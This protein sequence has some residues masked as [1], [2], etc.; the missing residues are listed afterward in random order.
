MTSLTTAFWTADTSASVDDRPIGAIL[1]ERATSTPDQ[2]ALRWCLGEEVVTTTYAGLLLQTTDAAQRLVAQA[3]ERG[4]VAVMAAGSPLWVVIEYA[5][6]LAGVA[7]V[8]IDPAATDTEL[9][10]VLSVTAVGLL[11]CDEKYEGS[12]LL[13]R[14]RAVAARSRQLVR[15]P[16]VHDLARWPELDG[17]G[18]DLPT[19]DASDPFLVQPTTAVSRPRGAVVISHRAAYNSGRLQMRHLGGNPDD[20]WFNMASL[21]EV[22][23]SVGGVLAMLS[24]GGAVALARKTDAAAVLRSLELTRA[25]VVGRVPTVPVAL[26]DDPALARTDTSSVRAVVAGAEVVPPSAVQR[27]EE[28]LGADVIRVYDHAG[29]PSAL[30]TSPSDDDVTKAETVGTPLPRHDVRVVR[31]SGTTADC[32]EHGEL[33]IRSLMTMDG[34][35]GAPSDAAA[36]ID[37]EGWL[38]TGDLASMDEHG[39]VRIHGRVR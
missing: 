7:L 6:A 12:P 18:T 11:L 2:P 1:R 31:A 16:I 8:P 9:E 4:R 35:L 39:V 21:H 19:V 36:A 22:A 38:H 34:Y 23:G 26:A 29:A 10:R 30:M 5:A 32:G 20:C 25:T 15:E 24:I 14:A 33:L 17:D 37:N 13:K 28:A 27:V 3:G